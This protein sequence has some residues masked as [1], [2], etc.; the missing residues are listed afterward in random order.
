MD[1]NLIENIRQDL[2]DILD[3][4]F[5]GFQMKPEKP[6]RHEAKF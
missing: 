1:S 6:I 5:S 3:F 2:L 4:F